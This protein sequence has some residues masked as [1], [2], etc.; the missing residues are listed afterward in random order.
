MIAFRIAIVAALVVCCVYVGALVYLFEAP[1]SPAGPVTVYTQHGPYTV[2]GVAPAAA[3]GI[4]ALARISSLMTMGNASSLLEMAATLQPDTDR[5]VGVVSRSGSG[6]GLAPAFSMSVTDGV[7]FDVPVSVSSGV[8]LRGQLDARA[9]LA[10]A[11][12]SLVTGVGNGTVVGPYVA[13]RTAYSEGADRDG[14]VFPA[15]SAHGS[16]VV[17]DGG[18]VVVEQG[19]D[20]LVSYSNNGTTDTASFLQDH[21][22]FSS[23][24]DALNITLGM[25]EQERIPLWVYLGDLAQLWSVAGTSITVTGDLI[26]PTATFDTRLSVLGQADAVYIVDTHM[27][28][29]QED[30]LCVICTQSTLHWFPFIADNDITAYTT[31]ASAA[32]DSVPCT[33][34]GLMH[35]ACQQR[36]GV[37]SAVMD[38]S[39]SVLRCCRMSLSTAV[40]DT[41]HPEVFVMPGLFNLSQALTVCASVGAR[42]AT[43]REWTAARALGGQW[44]TVAWLGDRTAR[45][46]FHMPSVREQTSSLAAATCYGQRP[47]SGAL[48]FNANVDSA[49][50]YPWVSQALFRGR[51]LSNAFNTLY[52][53]APGASCPRPATLGQ[54]DTA[55]QLG[56]AAAWGMCYGLPPSAAP[57]VWPPRGSDPSLY[58]VLASSALLNRTEAWL[59]A[60]PCTRPATYAQLYVA[61]TRG[62]S[63]AGG[64]QVSNGSVYTVSQ[65]A[66]I[67]LAPSQTPAWHLCYGTS[68]GA[69]M[70]ASGTF[71]ALDAE[72]AF[73]G[74]ALPKLASPRAIYAGPCIA[75]DD[76]ASQAQILL[77]TT[78]L[79]LVIP[80]A[81]TYCIGPAGDPWNEFAVHREHVLMGV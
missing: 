32:I 40:Y 14:V 63:A 59:S 72:R 67:A 3:P 74:Q 36:G 34:P 7:R 47:A 1:V 78:V 53:A 64:V 4:S 41:A 33:S 71:S 38:G 31:C 25:L 75:G 81:A 50:A 70:Y 21:A 13:P 79:Q 42:L 77:A 39:T 46:L 55:N 54:I 16:V 49:Y 29:D 9:S 65:T 60:Q 24:L 20:V 56:A 22:R 57:Y 80:P 45:R 6:V 69:S 51:V 58:E 48:P 37:L 19:G 76:T 12:P 30:C 52:T 17:Q 68:P 11:T 2:Y 66:L 10:S 43:R 62:L 35:T 27:V 8:S 23:L 15:V 73:I 26:V 44:A 18:N 28:L 61:W 5:M